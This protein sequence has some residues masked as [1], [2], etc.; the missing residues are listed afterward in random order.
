MKKKYIIVLLIGIIF[1]TGCEMLMNTP[2]KRVE[3]LLSMYQ[4]HDKEVLNQLDNVLKEETILSN[5]LKDR[6]R[7]LLKKQYKD[8][9][10]KIKNETIDGNTAVV[11]V[12]IEVYDYNKAINEVETKVLNEPEEFLNEEG[13]VLTT[14]FNEEKISALEKVKDRINYTINFTVSKINDKWIVDEL[15]ET[16]RLKLHGLYAY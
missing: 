9:T 14:K 16:E 4:T 7:N 6:F 10:Y 1:L 8:M 13:N 3:K 15:T 2:T 12:L 5:D 11:E